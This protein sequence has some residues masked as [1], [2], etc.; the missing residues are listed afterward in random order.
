M[1]GLPRSKRVVPSSSELLVKMKNPARGEA[2]LL[3]FHY[4][5]T[6]NVWGEPSLSKT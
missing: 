6:C 5:G 3:G 4:G 2:G 1:K